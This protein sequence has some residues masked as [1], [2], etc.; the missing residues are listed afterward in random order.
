[1]RLSLYRYRCSTADLASIAGDA[2]RAPS[3]Q[4]VRYRSVWSGRNYTLPLPA[5]D[6][7]RQ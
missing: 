1:M 6:Y 5:A 4:Q 3:W 2:G 7:G